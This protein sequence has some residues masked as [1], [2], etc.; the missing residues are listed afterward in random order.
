MSLTDVIGP[1]SHMLFQSLNISSGW[2]AKQVEQWSSDPDFQ[3]AENFVRSVKVVNDAAE[4]GV[5]LIS[6]FATKITTDP[7]QR[8]AL[9]QLVEMDHQKYPDFNKAT[10]SN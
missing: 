9:L 10:M 3:I 7:I 5:K 8:Q 1:E 4:R 6:D 2:L